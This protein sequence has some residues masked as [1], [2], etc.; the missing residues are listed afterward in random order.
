[1]DGTEVSWDTLNSST[2]ATCRQT[3]LDLDYAYVAV[4]VLNV[5]YIPSWIIRGCYRR[6]VPLNIWDLRNTLFR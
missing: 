6:L 2:L 4:L 3:E 1:M 5:L